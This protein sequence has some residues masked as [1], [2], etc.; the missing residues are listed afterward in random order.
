MRFSQKYTRHMS[1]IAYEKLLSFAKRNQ[2]NNDSYGRNLLSKVNRNE[3]KCNEY[4][5]LT[6]IWNLVSDCHRAVYLCLV[7]APKG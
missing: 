5:S 3:C 2:R 1:K 7:L 6:D 4:F